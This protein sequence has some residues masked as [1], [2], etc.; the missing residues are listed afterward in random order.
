MKMN[1][2]FG[3]FELIE[4]I[5]AGG[6]ASVYL[7]NQKALGR[8]VVLKVLYPHLAEDEKLVARFEREARAAAM[9]RHENIIQV[10]DM[11]RHEDVVYIA[12]EYV[13]G[14]DL[15]KWLDAH[16][17]P[18]LEMAILMLRDL[19]RGL[20]H[21]HGHHIV[22][23][24]IKPA[25]VMLTPDGT[26]K[27]MDF[28]LARGNDTSTQVTVV[29]SV[30]G[31]PAYMSPEQATGDVVDQ[32]SDV[33]ST[34]VVAYEL[35]GGQRPFGGESYSTVL[36]SILTVEP[37]DV[38]RF[39]PLVPE[40]LS[41]VVRGT[42]QKDVSKRVA[43]ITSLR[44]ALEDVI[45]QMG[46]LRGRDLLREYVA[47]PDGIAA[48]Y[49]QKRLARHLDQG[50][51]FENMG[52]GRIDDALLE[53]H[54]VLHLD[55]QNSVA[56]EHVKRL[57]HEREKVVAPPPPH[58]PA[59]DEHTVVLRPE[60]VAAL[61]SAAPPATPA[62][63]STPATPATPA[64]PAPPAATTP[65]TPKPPPPPAPPAKPA[66]P[67]ARPAAPRATP[68]AAASRR[69]GLPLPALIGAA[70]VLI[71]VV[72]FAFWR[73]MPPGST[74]TPAPDSTVASTDVPAVPSDSAP[75][76]SV[77]TAMA[78]SLAS[79]LLAAT[80]AFDSSDFE[81][82]L[83]LARKA[84]ADR[85]LPR[86]DLRP[87]RELIARSLVRLGRVAEAGRAFAELLTAFPGYRPGP[88]VTSAERGVFETAR[89]NLASAHPDTAAPA[90]P[91]PPPPG[92]ASATLRVTAVPFAATFTVDGHMLGQNQ[93]EFTAALAPGHH[94]VVLKHPS[95]GTREWS[96]EL[97]AGR[98]TTLSHDFTG[99]TGSI[100][101][102]SEPTWGDLYMDGV[103]IGKTTPWEIKAVPPG[104]H[105]VT[106]VR[107]GFAVE[108]GAQIVE[109]RPGEKKTVRFKLR[110][111][112]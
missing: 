46:L 80:A 94:T 93:Q 61:S 89:L 3:A 48:R 87:A 96:V 54:R 20:E 9:M 16:G 106:L 47:D 44:E 112:K 13:E 62:P 1:K 109:L 103:R 84:I 28:G 57:E 26:I 71:A 81:G 65:S 37:P 70:V 110:P 101:V 90:P 67:P 69:K 35:M 59:A 85:T 33:F 53:F 21:A 74:P 111:K 14:M 104:R 63:P 82:A 24:D 58:A 99:S 72:A 50:M 23:R 105:E 49:R 45:E 2:D 29:G 64:P 55:P 76:E 51:Y 75:P 11:G 92:R 30:M 91:L 79:P 66:P 6:M 108:G 8:K 77:G 7:A 34:G 52:L 97:A 27:L 15:K 42:L 83:R 32:R 100:E 19:C 4:K 5:G 68:P 25:N 43:T 102:S 107:D 40:E 73:L 18:P 95:L 78:D 38:T 22:H 60:Q 31:T 88:G 36:R 56:R 17:T 10:I 41:R 86:K 12:M 39:N 98:T